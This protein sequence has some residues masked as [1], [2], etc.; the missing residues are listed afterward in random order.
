MKKIIAWALAILTCVPILA[1]A[2]PDF[3]RVIDLTTASP[4]GNIDP[5]LVNPWGFVLTPEFNLVVANNG[6][7]TTTIYTPT[8]GTIN[9]NPGSKA[10][11]RPSLF[12]NVPSSPTGVVQNRDE[13]S[14]LFKISGIK[15]RAAEFLYST[16]EGTILA[17]NKHVDRLNALV[18]IDRSSTGAV[19]KGLEIAKVNGKYF[20]YATDFYNAKIDVFNH[21]FEYV[22]SFTDT[23]IP[24]GYAPFNIRK[25]NGKLYV[26]YAKQ[27][28]PSNTDD[29]PGAGHGYVDI[30]S[31][32]GHFI[33]RLISDGNLNSPWGLEIAP[34]NFGDFSGALLVGNFG[35][36]F[37]NAYDKNTGSFLGQL[38]DET[39]API[40]IPGLWGLNV[41]DSH[42]DRPQLFFTAGPADET[43]GLLGTILFTGN[44]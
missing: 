14:F 26:T 34:D 23:T 16:E 21:N 35:D 13:D 40:Q 24:T 41:N 29:D 20:L 30:F 4:S 10:P 33:S 3:Y 42:P 12:V 1:S 37:I 44:D 32:K 8:G 38:F 19:Y 11:T 27:L 6:T 43:D 7:S 15:K 9:L 17:Y 18:V 25:L 28:P 22:K 5:R 31:L 36:G 2:D 39:L